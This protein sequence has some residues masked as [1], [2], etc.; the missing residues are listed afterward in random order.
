[1]PGALHAAG[2][3]LPDSKRLQAANR[4]GEH[5]PASPTII[6]KIIGSPMNQQASAAAGAPAEMMPKPQTDARN[7]GL[8]LSFSFG[9]SKPMQLATPATLD[10]RR[11]G[12]TNRT[13]KDR[14]SDLKNTRKGAYKTK[15]PKKTGKRTAALHRVSPLN[16]TNA[17]AVSTA[18]GTRD[19]NIRLWKK[20]P[21]KNAE[22][23]RWP[24]VKRI[25]KTENTAPQRIPKMAAHRYIASW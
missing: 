9:T 8:R 6:H 12:F 23:T 25:A 5:S 16:E 3:F 1:M 15:K 11:I 20:F 7:A 17:M 10:A 24:E 19:S 13:K 4:R 14:E 22:Y 21:Q 18:S 2:N